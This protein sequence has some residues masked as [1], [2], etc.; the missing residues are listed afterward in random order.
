MDFKARAEMAAAAGNPRAQLQT[1]ST[2]DYM[3]C[4]LE[5]RVSR[6]IP[7]GEIW[8]AGGRI[9]VGPKTRW[10]LEHEGRWPG[11]SR[12]SRG[13]LELERDRRRHRPPECL[14]CRREAPCECAGGP[15]MCSCG[16]CRAPLSEEDF[17]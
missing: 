14:F 4:G 8:H 3:H 12:Y 11:L 10:S 16:R 17:E 2:V 15:C 7:E 6:L 1:I 13:M 5:V 9:V